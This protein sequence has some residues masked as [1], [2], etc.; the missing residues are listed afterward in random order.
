LWNQSDVERIDQLGPE[1]AHRALGKAQELDEFR[2]PIALVSFS[3]I[4]E[5]R[6]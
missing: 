4:R 6:D 5:D 2:I 3:E 1:F